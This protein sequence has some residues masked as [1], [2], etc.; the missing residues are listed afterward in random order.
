VLRQK[1]QMEHK[2][3]TLRAALELIRKACCW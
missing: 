2:P 3:Q 1:E